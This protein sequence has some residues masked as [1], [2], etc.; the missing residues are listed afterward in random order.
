MNAGT[1]GVDNGPIHMIAAPLS[2]GIYPDLAVANGQSN[3]VSVLI[4]RLNEH[5]S[6]GFDFQTSYPVGNNPTKVV[7]LIPD[8]GLAG[9]AVFNYNDSTVSILMP[10]G[11]GY[12]QDGGVINPNG[13]GVLDIA[14]GDFNGDGIADLAI[15][16]A[17][18]N[19]QSY[20]TLYIYN[21]SPS[22]FQASV[23]ATYADESYPGYAALAVGDVNGDGNLDIVLVSL[24]SPAYVRI[25]L[26]QGDGSFVVPPTSST[27]D[28]AYDFGNN[29]QTIPY[30]SLVDVNADGVLDL[31]VNLGYWYDVLLGDGLGDFGPRSG[32]VIT[33]AAFPAQLLG[34]GFGVADL[35]H[36]G[37]PNLVTIGT[38]LPA[39][40]ATNQSVGIDLLLN[41]CQ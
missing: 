26:G 4:N 6:Q 23:I 13:N 30:A 19:N 37:R 33:P 10:D 7:A 35:N 14:A 41:V 32:T 16:E 3:T 11:G 25:F 20:P 31:V 28:E 8:A 18:Y 36:D 5:Q 9:L 34:T 24:A 12:F 22:G 39:A 38:V 1:Q 21:G 27:F 29:G 15:M 2:G 17:D 40:N